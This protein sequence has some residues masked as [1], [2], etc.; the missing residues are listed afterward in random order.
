VTASFDEFR[1]AHHAEH[2]TAFNR[3]CVAVGNAVIILGVVPLLL[4][5]WRSSTT[6]FLVGAAITGVGHVAEGN[7]PRALRDLARHPIWSVRADVGLA[8]DVIVGRH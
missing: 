5:R 8:R 1:D 3:W 7:L 6:A 4:R 2:Q